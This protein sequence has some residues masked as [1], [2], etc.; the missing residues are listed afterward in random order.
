AARRA[1]FDQGSSA[2]AGTVRHRR[3]LRLVR[4]QGAPGHDPRRDRFRR[5]AQDARLHLRRP[6][7][8][9]RVALTGNLPATRRVTPTRGGAG[10][11]IMPDTVV[12]SGS[13]ADLAIAG[14]IAT[15]RVQPE[16]TQQERLAK[17]RTI[18][19]GGLL[20]LAVLAASYTA[21]EIVLPI[22]LAFVLNLV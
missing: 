22:L 11:R 6:K 20:G 14:P 15:E 21:A 5:L 1:A 19:V 3:I 4:G 16:P 13:G 10:V 2:R 17:L 9:H 18:F 12:P 8:P 7:G